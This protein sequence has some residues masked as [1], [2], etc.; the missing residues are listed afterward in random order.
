MA[1][2]RRCGKCCRLGGPVL[3]LEDCALLQSFSE[4]EGLERSGLWLS[5]LVTL[6]KGELV[7]DDVVG[8]L[9]PLPEECVK[10]APVSGS[11][12]WICRFLKQE[13]PDQEAECQAY[14]FRPAQC[15]A[16]DCTNTEAIA[17]LYSHDRAS[18]EVVLKAA[19]AP[20]A[21]LA[22]LPAYEEMCAYERIAPLAR[23]VLPPINPGTPA[24][25]EA[26]EALLETVRYDI[27]FRRLCVERG[28]IP[29]GVL[30]FLLGRPLSETLD[31]FGLALFRDSRGLSLVR[32]GPGVYDGPDRLI[33]PGRE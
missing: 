19:G 5:D 24:E 1:V 3:H 29:A 25:K 28:Y 9:L 8:T 30:P 7:R 31:M 12:S 18:R 27:S 32:R 16:L 11:E 15:R 14:G 23:L 4:D 17:A 33:L 26:T 21:W 13:E 2:C 6:R 20:S 10:I 22:L